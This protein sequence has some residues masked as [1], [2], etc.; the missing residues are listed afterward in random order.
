[1]LGDEGKFLWPVF[2]FSQPGRILLCC[3]ARALSCAIIKFITIIDVSLQ[4]ALNVYN[5]TA[6]TD[7]RSDQY[8]LQHI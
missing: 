5:E 4:K 1:M 8:W 6:I 2:T 7:L 3:K